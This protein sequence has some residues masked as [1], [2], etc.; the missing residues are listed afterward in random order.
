MTTSSSSSGPRVSGSPC[1]HSDSNSSEKHMSR[2]S[3]REGRLKVGFY[4]LGT[5]DS[6]K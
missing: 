3:Q 5:T 6:T 1:H 4:N 2:A